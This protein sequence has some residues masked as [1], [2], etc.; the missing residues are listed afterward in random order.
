MKNNKLLAVVALCVGLLVGGCRGLHGVPNGKHLYTGAEMELREHSPVPDK[1]ALKK[2]LLALTR[3]VPNTSFLGMRPRL[4]LWFATENAKKKKGLK[5]FIRKRLAEQ[6]VYYE[7]IDLDKN[8]RIIKNRLLNTGYFQA[9]V[10]SR[11]LPTGKKT[12]RTTYE[13]LVHT[14]YSIR[15]VVLPPAG[16]TA[17]NIVLAAQAQTLLVAGHQYSLDKLIAERQRLTDSMM[18]HGYFHWRSDFFLW[19]VDSTNSNK[20]VD[21]FLT[22]KSDLPRNANRYYSL[23]DVYIYPNFVLGTDTA[24]GTPLADTLSLN[25]PGYYY[26]LTPENAFLPR[27]I[28]ENIFFN[29]G[30][31]YSKRAHVQTL[32][33]LTNM[34]TFKFV[35]LTFAETDTSQYKGKLNVQINLTPLPRRTLRGKIT[36]TSKSN[37]FAGPGVEANLINRNLLHGAEQLRINANASFETQV[38]GNHSGPP[39]NSYEIGANAELQVPRF[40]TP[41]RMRAKNS[42]QVP[43]T[44]FSLGVQRLSRVRYF[45]LNSFNLGYGFR[46]NETATKTHEYYPVAV[47]FLQLGRTTRE[48]DSLVVQNPYLEQSYERQFI[49]GSTYQY[50]FNTQVNTDRKINYYFNGAMDVSGNLMQL[51]QTA[52]GGKG[53]GFNNQKSVFGV[54]YSQYAKVTLDF[55]YNNKLTKKGKLATRLVLG[56]GKAYGNSQVLP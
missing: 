41:F 19:K 5:A 33:R 35:N 15:K 49:L 22:I 54:P 50:T 31:A 3:P 8:E 4:W 27:P 45:D 29:Q 13:A 42:S 47:S 23:N 43:K 6:P 40:V 20:T 11:D 38:G 14:P 28:V 32:A 26:I 56:V 36:L 48:F 18:E 25:E 46:W 51:A 30:E 52:V 21:V 1:K 16:A 37:N 39:L 55:R 24:Y 2:E 10:V 17:N 53:E 9:Q 34:G 44:L 12:M 7:D